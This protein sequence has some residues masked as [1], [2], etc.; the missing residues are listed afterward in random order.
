[1]VKYICFIISLL[2]VSFLAQAQ[3]TIDGQVVQRGEYRHGFSKLFGENDDPAAFIGQRARLQAGY[4]LDGLTMQVSVQDVRVWGNT[5]QAKAS[6]DFLSVHEAWVAWQFNEHWN[7]KAGRQ[8][9]NFDNARFLGNLDWALQARAHDFALIN[10]EKNKTKISFGGGYNQNQMSNTKI[11]YNIAGQYQNAQ[12]FR[13]EQQVSDLSI[14]L[15]FWNEGRQHTSLTDKPVFYRQTFGI[16]NLSYKFKNT[17]FSAFYYQQTGKN[18]TGKEVNA[19]DLSAKVVHH[20]ILNAEKGQKLGV[21]AGLEMLS[22]TA[23]NESEKSNS[24][25]PLYGT[26]HAH[27]GYMDLFF[28]GNHDNS[29]GLND[30]YAKMRYDF[31]PKHFIQ[32][33]FHWFNAQAEVLNSASETLDAHLGKEIDF[34]AGY[35]FSQ[36]FSLQAGYSHFLPGDTFK[37]LLGGNDLHKT[38]NWAYLMLIFRPNNKAKFI[39]VSL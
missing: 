2:F 37:H 33:N 34:S 12:L 32:A 18:P 23:T 15:L 20:H 29:V 28:V 8:E 6:D 25:A 21:A 26:N 22:G 39:G 27:N 16:P 1:M 14:S 24:F 5:T 17:V 30:F 10:Y 31:N 3:F 11:D 13:L 35:I 19:F 7:I 9:L 36:A 4:K 38:Q